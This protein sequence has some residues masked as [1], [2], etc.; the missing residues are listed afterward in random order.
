MTE[1][2]NKSRRGLLLGLAGLSAVAAGWQWVLK[3]PRDLVFLPIP[4]L[5]GWQLMETNAISGGAAT[6]AVFLGIEAGDPVTPLS[7]ADLCRRLYPNPQDKPTIAFF[8]DVQCPNCASLDA[9]L[10]ALRDRV[11]LNRIE[12]PLLGVRS[13]AVAKANLAERLGADPDGPEVAARLAKNHAAAKTLGIWGT[14]AFTI[15]RTLVMG[16][17]PRGTLETLLTLNHPT[18]A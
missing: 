6:S 15:G 4:G 12:L 17:V 11:H 3:R 10:H 7:S 2:K 5:P 14:P 13:V 8:T 1:T 9:K 16:D 18:C